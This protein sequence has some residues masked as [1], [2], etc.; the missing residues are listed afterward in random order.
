MKFL[1]KLKVRAESLDDN[2]LLHADERM[3]IARLVVSQDPQE[4][5]KLGI[6]MSL[7]SN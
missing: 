1:L 4:T 5:K 3:I 7:A 6:M 2:L